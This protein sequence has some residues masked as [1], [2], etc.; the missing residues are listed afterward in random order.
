MR[1]ETPMDAKSTVSMVLE[2]TCTSLCCLLI[3]TLHQTIW[4]IP[5]IIVSIVMSLFGKHNSAQATWI[6]AMEHIGFI[7]LLTLVWA[8]TSVA[9]KTSAYCSLSIWI[10]LV[11]R[12]LKRYFPPKVN[13][14]EATNAGERPTRQ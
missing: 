8:E 14:N 6:G 9:F 1:R 4:Y 7:L 2:V 12:S 11:G 13:P 5:L 10:W 3:A